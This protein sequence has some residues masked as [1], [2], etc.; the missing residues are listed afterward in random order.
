MVGFFVVGLRVVGLLVV[1]LLVGF[2]VGNL[3][4]E[5]L[6]FRVEG[7]YVG[8]AVVGVGVQATDKVK[9]PFTES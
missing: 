1:G 8:V 5:A 9:F 6:G 4:G 7:L 3:D 2:V